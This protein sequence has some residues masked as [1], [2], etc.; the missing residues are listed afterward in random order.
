MVK[1]S[2]FRISK[3]EHQFYKIAEMFRI[4]EASSDTRACESLYSCSEL[5]AKLLK[6]C[7]DLQ[8]TRL[9]ITIPWPNNS[10]TKEWLLM[11]ESI[12]H[13]VELRYAAGFPQNPFFLPLVNPVES[14]LII[15][16]HPKREEITNMLAARSAIICEW[17]AGM[18]GHTSNATPCNV[19]KLYK[20][21]V[22]QR[23][24][25]ET[26]P[27]PYEGWDISY[28]GGKHCVIETIMRWKDIHYRAFCNNGRKTA[29]RKLLPYAIRDA[30]RINR[31]GELEPLIFGFVDAHC[32]FLRIANKFTPPSKSERSSG[33]NG[34]TEYRVLLDAEQK[35]SDQ[36]AVVEDSTTLLRNNVDIEYLGLNV[37]REYRCITRDGLFDVTLEFGKKG[38]A[39][40]LFKLLFDSREEG[41]TRDGLTSELWTKEVSASRLDQV[42]SELN[43][44]LQPIRCEVTT[45]NRGTWHLCEF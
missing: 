21:L 35:L 9:R 25:I 43:D 22:R 4:I 13:C 10:E 44:L 30:D 37:D 7:V 34:S 17:L 40:R 32:D 23:T 16:I 20:E 45:D 31:T 33:I 29:A 5:A 19:Q 2:A 42:K 11:W 14:D 6:R 26:L 28:S 38:V 1:D 12:V 3:P 39:W 8:Q 41:M 27:M 36:L 24:V 15:R 18:T